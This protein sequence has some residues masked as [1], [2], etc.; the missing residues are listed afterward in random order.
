MRKLRQKVKEQVQENDKTQTKRCTKCQK[1]KPYSAF[2]YSKRDVRTHLN[3]ICDSCLTKIYANQ[4]RHDETM[5]PAW[6]RARAYGA[7]QVMRVRV[8]K[9]KDVP[10]SSVSLNDLSWVCNPMD[11]IQLYEEQHHKCCYCGVELTKANL[12]VDHKQPVS[13]DGKHIYTNLALCC[14]DCNLLKLDK[15]EEEFNKFLIDYANR[16]INRTKG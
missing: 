12:G 14:K 10:M 3:K 11:L 7:N 9:Q 8:A 2:S 4:N 1:L 5:T 6:W 16:I 15:T 13:R